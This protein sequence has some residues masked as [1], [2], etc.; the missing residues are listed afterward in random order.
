MSEKIECWGC[1]DEE[2][3]SLDMDDTIEEYLRNRDPL[4]ITIEVKGYKRMIVTASDLWSPLEDILDNLD[5]EYGRP[6]DWD[7]TVHSDD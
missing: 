6:D 2:I 5:S 1:E 7:S 4:P 3:L